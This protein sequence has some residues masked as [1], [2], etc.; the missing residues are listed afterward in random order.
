MIQDLRVRGFCV[1]EVKKASNA[2]ISDD[3]SQIWA[4]FRQK[5]TIGHAGIYSSFKVL[6]YKIFFRLTK[7]SLFDQG[8]SFD[9]NCFEN[10]PLDHFKVYVCKFSIWYWLICTIACLSIPKFNSKWIPAWCDLW[11][12]IGGKIILLFTS[13]EVQH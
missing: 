2:W 3:K 13:L 6:I 9:R 5:L 7:F 10:S 12:H 4:T 8:A 1:N 11:R